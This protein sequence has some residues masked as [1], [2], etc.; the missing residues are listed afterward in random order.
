LGKDSCHPFLERKDK[1][2]FFLCHTSNPGATEFQE[3]L[4]SETGLDDTKKKLW[5]KPIPLYQFM[6]MKIAEEWNENENCGLV[7]GATYPEQLSTVRDIVGDMPILIPGIGTQQGDI[8]STI[9]AGKDSHNRGMIISS[10]RSII[11][12]SDQSDFGLA[13]R[14]VTIELRDKI[15]S[16]L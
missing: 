1:G 6:A 5:I 2:L 3:L 14:K 10:S 8:R 11:Y 16:Y 12:A 7:V 13:S 9:K 15:N 4:V